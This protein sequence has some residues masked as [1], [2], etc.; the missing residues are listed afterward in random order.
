MFT[1]ITLS[2]LTII[3]LIGLAGCGST[4]PTSSDSNQGANISGTDTSGVIS[5]TTAADNQMLPFISGKVADLKLD[6]SVEGTTQQM[7]KGEVMAITLESNPSTGY[8]WFA[9]ISDDLVVAQM[10]ESEYNEPTQSATPVIGAPGTQ[11]FYFEA[12]DSGVATI[13]LEYKRGWEK[14]VAADKTIT[15]TVEVE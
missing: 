2:I 12:V 10:G 4:S 9:T 6:A 14:D 8:S 13:T 1:K 5:D 15:L 3:L 7:K 11:T